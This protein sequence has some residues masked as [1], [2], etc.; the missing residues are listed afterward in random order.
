[1]GV[2][3]IR[4]AIF[5]RKITRLRPTRSW[6]ASPMSSPGDDLPA[7]TQPI[8]NGEENTTQAGQDITALGNGN[9]G[10]NWACAMPR[11]RGVG[12]GVGWMQTS[13]DIGAG[14]HRTFRGPS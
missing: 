6:Y 1:M 13:P 10:V 5:V 11:R 12:S 9:G 14:V 7:F 3:P 2:A 4:L 8:Y